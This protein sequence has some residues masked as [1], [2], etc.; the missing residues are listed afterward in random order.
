[1]KVVVFVELLLDVELE[2]LELELVGLDDDELELGSLLAEVV[3]G[4]LAL[5]VTVAAEVL[6]VEVW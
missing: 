2:L 1:V 5:L 4:L 6:L 3:A